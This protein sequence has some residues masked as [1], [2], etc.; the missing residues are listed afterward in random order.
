VLRR[1]RLGKTTVPLQT[2][3]GDY[4][5]FVLSYFIVLLGETERNLIEKQT[6]KLKKEINERQS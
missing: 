3:H 5:G 1:D 4:F 6:K 2:T